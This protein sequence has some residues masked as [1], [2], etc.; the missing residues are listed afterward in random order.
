MELPGKVVL[1]TGASAGIGRAAVHTLAARGARLALVARSAG[2]LA[3]LAAELSVAGAQ[4]LALPADVS[5]PAQ[6]ATAVTTCL[7][8]YGRLDVLINNAGIG[9]YGPT[10]RTAPAD[11]QEIFATNTL[12]PMYLVHAA[13]PAMV[14]QG[15]GVIMNVSS[16]L[17]KMVMP[18]LAA[19]SATKSALDKLTAALRAE[20]APAGIRVLEHNP[21]QTHTEIFARTVGESSPMLER[22]HRGA[23]S[24]ESV[25]AKLVRQIETEKPVYYCRWQSRLF[26]R[27]VALTGPGVL[28]R[29]MA[30]LLAEQGKT[31]S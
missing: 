26:A 12:A 15:G 28:A 30:P 19:Y 11:L 21:G 25:A 8:H 29:R 1:L 4:A 2:R 5:D 20:L 17:G 10:A 14:G 31:P 6:A 24:A 3:T 7:Q 13:V 16:P 27:L 9:K 22:L 18:Y 23:E